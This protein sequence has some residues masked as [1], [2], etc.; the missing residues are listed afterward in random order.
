[1]RAMGFCLGNVIMSLVFTFVRPVRLRVA[2]RRALSRSVDAL[3][4]MIRG[5]AKDAS[6]SFHKNLAVARKQAPVARLEPG[7]DDRSSLIPAIESLF[8]PIQVI[9]QTE[10]VLPA[11]AK[12]ALHAVADPIANWV[13]DLARPFKPKLQ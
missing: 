10:G 9:S 6:A 13:S 5:E 2:V 7:E 1:G 11:S 3:A 12:E 8:V 4:A